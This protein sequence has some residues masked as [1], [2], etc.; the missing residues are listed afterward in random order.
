MSSLLFFPSSMPDET[1]L[2]RVSRYH[3]LSG[4]KRESETFWDL[5]GT[6]PFMFGI[7]PKQLETL[8][9]RLPGDAGSNRQELI[10]MNT[11]FPAYRPFS[12]LAIDSAIA[13]DSLGVARVPRREGLVHQKG[14]F[15][16]ACI[17]HDM[18]NLGHAY[19]HRAHQLPGVSACWRHGFL[20]SSACPKCSHPFVRSTKLLSNFLD[21]CACGWNALAPVNS[22]EASDIDKNYALFSYEVLQLNL[23]AISWQTLSSCYRRQS[24]KK[25]YGRGELINKAKLMQSIEQTYGE[26]SLS[27]IDGAYAAGKRHQ[28][29]RFTT[30]RG[31]IDM[32]L[33]RHILICHHLFG[34]A[35]TLQ[36]R[37]REEFQLGRHAKTVAPVKT[38]PD[39]KNKRTAFRA[40]IRM[41]LEA[42][43]ATGVDYM[44]EHQYQATR[45]LIENDKAWLESVLSGS[46]HSVIQKE[47]TADPRDKSLADTISANID[48]LY[49]ISKHQKR[50]NITNILG[51]LPTAAVRLTTTKRK[52]RFPLVSHQL[53]LHIESRWHFLLRRIVW[54]VAEMARLNLPPTST[55]HDMLST[56]PRQAWVAI[57]NFFEWDLEKLTCTDLDPQQLLKST[58]VTRQWNGPPGHDMPM[59]G[60]AYQ[61]Q[62]QAQRERLS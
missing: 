34:D 29:I 3:F 26:E 52:E 51:L 7:L 62:I 53:E 20:L 54:A 59:G 43:P 24:V 12:G 15:C 37:L 8:A 58:G 21:D 17:Q 23:P 44:W 39:V 13:R 14:K 45:W 46:E 2:S 1:L 16:L 49:Q 41:L 19:M 48:G 25:G 10:N 5:F 42:K 40:K 11:A 31:Q 4:N 38:Q 57:V 18:L 56:T 47:P 30:T 27:R 9:E 35:A 60:H 6:A 22:T 61:E 55:S 50:A 32:P 33:A 28:W 36:Q